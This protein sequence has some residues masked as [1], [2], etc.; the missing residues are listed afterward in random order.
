MS[1]QRSKNKPTSALSTEAFLTAALQLAEEAGELQQLSLRKLGKALNVDPTA[2]YRYFPNKEAL[3]TAMGER[4]VYDLLPAEADMA[5]DWRSRIKALAQCAYRV[6]STY[7]S[8]SIHLPASPHIRTPVGDQVMELGYQALTDAGLSDEHV[9]LFHELL[10]TFV[11]GMGQ[12]EA[13][14]PG[15]LEEERSVT[16]ARVATLPLEAFAN[17]HRLAPLMIADNAAVFELYLELY[18]AAIEFY[19]NRTAS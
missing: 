17:M 5:G 14:F 13:Q 3:I 2:V 11:L 19:A 15:S 7:P 12:I 6:C 16:R 4:I 18:L 10:Y 9:V 8:I 1:E